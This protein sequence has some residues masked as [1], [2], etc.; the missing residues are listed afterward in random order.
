MENP[1]SISYKLTYE[2][3]NVSKKIINSEFLIAFTYSPVKHEIIIRTLA[4]NVNL[5][6][7]NSETFKGAN[8]GRDDSNLHSEVARFYVEK[9]IKNQSVP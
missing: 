6:T 2:T 8:N 4:R 3:E 9:F 1:H 7:A 5:D